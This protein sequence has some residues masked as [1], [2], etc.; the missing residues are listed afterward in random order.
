MKITAGL[1][2]IATLV[3]LTHEDA[4]FGYVD[5]VNHLKDDRVYLFSGSKD[6]VVHPQVMHS[7]RTY[8]QNFISPSQIVSDFNVPSEHC[9]PTDG[10]Y[11][12]ECASLS[13]PYIGVCNFDGARAAL[14]TLFGDLKPRVTAIAANLIR[15]SQSPYIQGLETSLADFG[16]L[17]VPTACANGQTCHLHISFHGCLQTEADIG[18]AYATKSGYNEW[19]EANNIIMLYPYAKKSQAAPLNPN[20]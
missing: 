2:N 9:I 12:E 17:Y 8:Y 4:A 18:D 5:P 13:S 20:G 10:T 11:G 19:A 6:T 14:T 16:Y 3:T 7:L 15:F 1:P